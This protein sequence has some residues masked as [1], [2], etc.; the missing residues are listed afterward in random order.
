[1]SIFAQFFGVVFLKIYL[2]R[3]D[4]KKNPDTNK[5]TPFILEKIREYL[6]LMEKRTKLPKLGA[7]Q[8][9]AF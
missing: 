7:F 5:D 2:I 6:L 9:H 1:M 4:T 3:V 8:Y